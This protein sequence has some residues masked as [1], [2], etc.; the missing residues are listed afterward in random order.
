MRRDCALN[1]K[2]AVILDTQYVSYLPEK[3]VTKSD[4]TRGPDDQV[5]RRRIPRIQT[6]LQQ[7]FRYV[8]NMTEEDRTGRLERERKE[9][10][11][12]ENK[13]RTSEGL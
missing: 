4:F 10:N 13:A 12:C 3:E 7:L 9:G 1:I 5:R 6:P 2:T 11:L 8:T